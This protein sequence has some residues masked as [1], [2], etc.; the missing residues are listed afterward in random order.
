MNEKKEGQIKIMVE[1]NSIQCQRKIQ[2]KKN[3]ENIEVKY[4]TQKVWYL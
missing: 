2:G 3:W 4:S 1:Q